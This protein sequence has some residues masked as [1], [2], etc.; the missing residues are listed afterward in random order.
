MP[1]PAA[2]SSP[3][4]SR[5][6][7]ASAAEV[8]EKLRQHYQFPRDFCAVSG[9]ESI[10]KLEGLIAPDAF[11][12]QN[13]PANVAKGFE[14]AHRIFLDT[15][16]LDAKDE[17]YHTGAAAALVI[18]HEVSAGRFPLVS[19]PVTGGFHVYIFAEDGG[20]LLFI[21]PAV[22]KVILRGLDALPV[23]LEN[24]RA[25]YPTKHKTIHVLTYTR[26][27]T[28]GKTEPANGEASKAELK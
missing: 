16:G 4:P 14:P 5:A 18:G 25:N 24:W 6:V 20:Q 26:R 22:P 21:D 19:M 3:K 9:F 1:D 8:P 12:L 15:L 10:A 27:A 13:D 7:A 23:A 2:N 11:P 28:T 17:H